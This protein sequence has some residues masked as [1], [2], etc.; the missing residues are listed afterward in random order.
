MATLVNAVKE[1]NTKIENLEKQNAKLVKKL[2]KKPKK[3]ILKY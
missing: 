1:L 2:N 3:V